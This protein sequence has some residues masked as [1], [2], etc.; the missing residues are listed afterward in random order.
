MGAA[1]AGGWLVGMS[2]VC[3]AAAGVAAAVVPLPLPL[4]YLFFRA[5]II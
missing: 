3:D 4:A 5:D 1:W 2:R